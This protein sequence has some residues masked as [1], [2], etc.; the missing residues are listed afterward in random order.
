M[1]ELIYENIHVAGQ[2]AFYESVEPIYNPNNGSEEMIAKISIASDSISQQSHAKIFIW[3]DQNT[4]WNLVH[5]INSSA[6]K[7]L[8]GLS[9]V[10]D[11]PEF[12]D[13]EDDCHELKKA[14]I[15]IVF[16]KDF[17]KKKK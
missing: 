4:C 13:F 11:D 8:H 6:M 10:P 5:E 14:A 2:R 15:R 9:Y 1:K 12:R 3:N 17:T 16:G 7:T